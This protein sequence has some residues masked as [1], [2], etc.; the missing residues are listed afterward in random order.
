MNAIATDIKPF[1][2][3]AA[4][5]TTLRAWTSGHGPHRW[6]LT[7]GLGT[8][9]VCWKHVLE[10]F[11][12]RMT[13]VTWDPR[14]C[15][16]SAVPADLGRL[17]LEDHVAD[18]FAVAEAVGWRGVPH[19]VGGWSM[20]V[21][22]GL[23]MARQAPAETCGLT[24]VNGTFEHVLRTAFHLPH[25]DRLLTGIARVASAGAAVASPAI[26][27]ML[28]QPWAISLLSHAGIVNANVEFFEQVVREFRGLDFGVYFKMMLELN[29][30]SAREALSQVRAPT[31]VTAGTHDLMTP[32]AV[33]RFMHEQIAGSEL[34]VIPNGT[35]YA[36]LEYPELLNLKLEQFF[37]RRVFG[38]AWDAAA[39]APA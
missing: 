7:P 22:I 12:D 3:R 9:V 17:R 27:H 8:P 2:V 20:G 38:S 28:G 39:A 15:Y 32:L 6:L 13:I 37:R 19:V 11:A 33:A 30:H 25:A 1:F 23:E 34:F 18:G 31:L 4:D 10:Y 21:Q 14:A 35:H 5:G 16:G 36:S 26:R 24:L 29:E